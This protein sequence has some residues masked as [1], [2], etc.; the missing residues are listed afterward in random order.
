MFGILQVLPLINQGW[1]LVRGCW[2]SMLKWM[3]FIP[4]LTKRVRE[5]ESNTVTTGLE[6]P[7][8]MKVTKE[9]R[10]S[11]WANNDG[12]EMGTELR[13]LNW[14]YQG[15]YE[16]EPKSKPRW[17]P[18]KPSH[19]LNLFEY[20]R[21]II[22]L[23]EDTW[24]SEHTAGM[25]SKYKVQIQHRD[26]RKTEQGVVQSE[27]ARMTYDFLKRCEQMKLKVELNLSPSN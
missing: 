5:S 23:D 26:V 22:M 4:L 27:D 16:P 21:C 19:P 15:K 1:P 8:N 25:E 3:P 10:Y 11:A 6:V 18:F 9:V 24:I 17:Y 2:K 7:S 20:I 12:G 13:D 14:D